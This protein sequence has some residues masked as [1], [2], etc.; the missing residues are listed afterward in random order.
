MGGNS[1][2]TILYHHCDSVR[3]DGCDRCALWMVSDVII[4]DSCRYHGKQFFGTE[5]VT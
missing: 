4:K 5:T 1:F 2:E 3:M